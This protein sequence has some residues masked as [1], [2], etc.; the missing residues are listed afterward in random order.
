MPSRVA[1]GKTSLDSSSPHLA[2]LPRACVTQ[3]ER[4]PTI[5]F[6]FCPQEHSS[7][8]GKIRPENCCYGLCFVEVEM[9]VQ[10]SGFL[11]ALSLS[12]SLCLHLSLSPPP[13][14]PSRLS[15]SPTPPLFLLS[16][17]SSAALPGLPPNTGA[18][19]EPYRLSMKPGII[20]FDGLDNSRNRSNE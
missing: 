12:L 8:G 7:A 3:A 9:L 11:I 20:S 17:P 6:L 15:L 16:P 19:G 14:T 13:P 4:N 10:E 2:L 1:P 5:L 18:G